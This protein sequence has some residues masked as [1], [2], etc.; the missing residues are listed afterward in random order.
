MNDV[1][2]W[3]WQ[4]NSVSA[5][6]TGLGLFAG[7]VIALG[8]LRWVVVR[9][10]SAAAARTATWVDDVL[11]ELV[12]QTRDWF[13]VIVGFSVAMKGVIVLHTGVA[14]ILHGALVIGMMVQVAIWV[15]GAIRFWV[16]HYRQS[17]GGD[18]T[19]VA[20]VQGFAFLARIALG[21]V[22]VVLTLDLLGV[23]VTTLVAGLGI[24]GIA[25][26][27]AVQNVLGDLFAALSIV[28]DKP[29]V[30]GDFIVVDNVEGT[31]E[32]VGLKTTRVRSIGGEQVIIAN[33]DLLKS[34]IRNYRRLAERRVALTFK[35]AQGT[36]PAAA[37]HF[38]VIL[39][40]IVERQKPIR[41][42][43]AHLTAIGDWSLQYEVVYI[44]LSP[45]YMTH[46][47]IQ[48][49]INVDV[50]ERLRSERMMLATPYPAPSS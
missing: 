36:D 30:I 44:V 27:L 4:G 6:L 9:R 34:R 22:L 26:A 49:Q 28:L 32:H 43:R 8:L 10:L 1:L 39:R 38:P 31:V 41:F 18:G 45:D 17:R 33:A 19:S 25:I 24:T 46:M 7:T 40:E 42:D 21:V 14:L 16:V 50:L 35:L 37:A 20:T 12:K 29:F 13:I 5:W 15:N 48:Q 11:V 2:G 3:T 23:K 47:N